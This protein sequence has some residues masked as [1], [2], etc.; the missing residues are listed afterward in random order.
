MRMEQLKYLVD[1]A[2][3]KSMSKTAERLFV[4][5]QAVSQSIKQL[6]TE[7]DTELLVRTN[8]GVL[9]TEI[10]EGVVERAKRILTEEDEM[11]RMIL[12]SKQHETENTAFRIRIGS[13]SAVTNIVLPSILAGFK[14][15]NIDVEPRISMVDNIN[16]LLEQ[17]KTGERDIGLLTF[18]E[19][20]L[21]QHFQ[22][23]RDVLDMNLLA[24]DE[25]VVVMER[26]MYQQGQA[27]VSVQEYRNHFRTVYSMLPVETL[28]QGAKDAMVIQSNDAEFHRA[29][30]KKAEAY[31]IMPRLAYQQFFSSK[32]YVALPLEGVQVTLLHV[33]VYRKNISEKVQNFI[34][35]IRL[36]MS[37]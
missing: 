24:R 20:K 37:L 32:S 3:T 17:V 4:S 13:T 1:I 34:S 18:N 11:N 19:E 31:V 26:R 16:A 14:R 15:A 2:E 5:P 27:Y 29:M 33:A 6:E 9:L 8:M 7:L 21:F 28:E 10:G 36:E 25:L 30:M 22:Q 12:A 35:Q 23:Y